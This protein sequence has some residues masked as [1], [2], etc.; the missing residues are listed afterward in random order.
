MVATERRSPG[1]RLDLKVRRLINEADSFVVLL[2][3]K[4]GQSRWVQQEIGAA[5][6][7]SKRIF[8]LKA[9]SVGVPGMLEGTEYLP[10]RFLNRR[11]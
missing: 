11:S 3:K 1:V 6:S 9:R 5:Q 10:F 7:Y 2:T 8:A 4:G